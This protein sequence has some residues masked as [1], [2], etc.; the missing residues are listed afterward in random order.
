MAFACHNIEE[1]GGK[2]SLPQARI[3][4]KG[5]RCKSRNRCTEKK[6]SISYKKKKKLKE[7]H[8]EHVSIIY[9][10]NARYVCLFLS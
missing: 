6:R 1:K 8:K 3:K 5:K 4:G 7:A 10:H 9:Q 2:K